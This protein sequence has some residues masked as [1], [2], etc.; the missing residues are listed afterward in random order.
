MG[1]V[2]REGG[3]FH[4]F[5]QKGEGHMRE[6]AYLRGANGEITVFNQIGTTPTPILKQVSRLELCSIW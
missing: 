6:G 3:L 5:T 2:I 4:F 1:G